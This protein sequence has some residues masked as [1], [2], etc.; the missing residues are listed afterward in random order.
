MR[1]EALALGGAFLIE[2][3][4][5]EDERGYFARTWCA[6]EF[7]AHGL[8]NVVSQCSI[9][10]NVRAGTLRGMHYQA[11]PHGEHK[12]VRCGRG[13]IYDVLLDLRPQSPTF[14]KWLAAELTATNGRMLFVPPGVAHGFQTLAPDTEV[15]Y[16]M[17]EP[18]HGP[19][20]RGVRWDDPCFAIDWPDA[21]ERIIS[22]KDRAYPDFA[23]GA[24]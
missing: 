20:A 18:F 19:S 4:R 9:S 15:H 24:S 1:F 10:Y 2:P 12:L 16:Q 23:L 3:E 14:L 17:A 8:K 6:A 7:E 5:L 13:A 11:E 21:R 22:A